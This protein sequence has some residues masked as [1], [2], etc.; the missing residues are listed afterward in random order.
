[1]TVHDDG[2][3]FHV[4][5]TGHSTVAIDDE[6]NITT[7]ANIDGFQY[8]RL[9]GSWLYLWVDDQFLEVHLNLGDMRAMR[10]HLDRQLQGADL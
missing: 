1:M 5:N 7:V 9:R 6:A 8:A 3:Q 2:R 4:A 10:R